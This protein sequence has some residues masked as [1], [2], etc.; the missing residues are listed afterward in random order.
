MKMA[1]QADVLRTTDEALTA[2]KRAGAAAHA[3][4]ADWHKAESAEW[5][6]RVLYFAFVLAVI[7]TV[8]IVIVVHGRP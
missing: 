5:P 4:F 3:K 1:T 8:A 2:E 6:R 7:L